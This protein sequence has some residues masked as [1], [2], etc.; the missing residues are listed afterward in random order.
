M[1]STLNHRSSVGWWRF[2]NS[3]PLMSWSRPTWELF[4][5]MESGHWELIWSYQDQQAAAHPHD[6]KLQ[7]GVFKLFLL[8]TSPICH[9]P[10]SIDRVSGQQLF[11]CFSRCLLIKE[12][13]CASNTFPDQWRSTDWAGALLSCWWPFQTGFHPLKQSTTIHDTTI[14]KFLQKVPF[15]P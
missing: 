10:P 11:S 2:C 8:F 3:F 6:L 1:V 12:V 13:S 15:A 9:S 5:V 14:Q 7:P 4:T